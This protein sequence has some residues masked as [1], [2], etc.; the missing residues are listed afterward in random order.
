MT[1]IKR[2]FN[3]HDFT[4][5]SCVCGLT[6]DEY[7]DSGQLPC[8]APPEPALRRQAINE[9]CCQSRVD[10]SAPRGASGI[11]IVARRGYGGPWTAVPPGWQNEPAIAE[12]SIGRAIAR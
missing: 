3:G 2:T 1:A 11:E 4:F 5:V 8:C 6:K 7:D 10:H 12:P 9:T